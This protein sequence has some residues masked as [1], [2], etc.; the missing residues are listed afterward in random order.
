MGWGIMGLIKR[1]IQYF[2]VTHKNPL[3]KDTEA[4]RNIYVILGTVVLGCLLLDISDFINALRQA[5]VRDK[6]WGVGTGG[7]E[8]MQRGGP[9]RT[10]GPVGF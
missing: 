9:H 1:V 4:E 6:W 7:S 5:S 3:M 10:K 8:G 2:L